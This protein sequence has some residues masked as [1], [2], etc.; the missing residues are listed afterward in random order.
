MPAVERVTQAGVEVVVRATAV[1]RVT[2]AG[3]EVVVVPARNKG[4]MFLVF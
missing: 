3:V 2:Q 4:N 1:E